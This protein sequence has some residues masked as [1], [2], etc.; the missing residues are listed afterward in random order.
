MGRDPKQE[1]V[2]LGVRSLAD[3]FKLSL[4]R[5]GRAPELDVSS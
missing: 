2:Y 3:K 4:H 5:Y 1:R